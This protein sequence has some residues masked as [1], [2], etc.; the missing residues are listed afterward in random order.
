MQHGARA[1]EKIARQRY[2]MKADEM[3]IRDSFILAHLRRNAGLLHQN[4]NLVN[5]VVAGGI[6]LE[7]V[8]GTLLVEGK[9]CIRDRVY[10]EPLAQMQF[11]QRFASPTAIF[12]HFKFADVDIPV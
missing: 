3:C 11:S 6:Q 5:T 2:F 1:F 12:R 7:D 9:M 8:V 10:T 4:L